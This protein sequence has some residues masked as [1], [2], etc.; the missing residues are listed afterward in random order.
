MPY[1][2]CTNDDIIAAWER[3]L[4]RHPAPDERVQLGEDYSSPRE[5]T[6]EM[7]T[8]EGPHYA[9]LVEKLHDRAQREGFD[10]VAYIDKLFLPLP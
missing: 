9:A 8:H 7:K 6:E 3:L 2:E 10:P 4:N 5:D 1:I